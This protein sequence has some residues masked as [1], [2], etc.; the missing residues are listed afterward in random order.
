SYAEI[1]LAR[2]ASQAGDGRGAVERSAQAIAAFEDQDVLCRSRMELDRARLLRQMDAPE[3]RKEPE[4][5]RAR[6]AR[7]GARRGREKAESRR[8][9]ELGR[10]RAEEM[11]ARPLVE[12]A[13][14]V[15]AY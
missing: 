8:E 5:L 6:G 3:P 15:L 10:A 7:M 14:A 12:K 4:P 11:G 2:L 1:F 9:A 13:E